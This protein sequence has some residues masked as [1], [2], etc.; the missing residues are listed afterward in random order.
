MFI[1]GD[2]RQV[3]TFAVAAGRWSAGSPWEKLI[4]GTATVEQIVD[5]KFVTAAAK[6]LGPYHPKR[7]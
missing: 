3:K 5:A 2:Q 1:G 4:D 7:G 6:Q